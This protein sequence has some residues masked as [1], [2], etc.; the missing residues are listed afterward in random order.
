MA[1][2]AI[3]DFAATLDS[4]CAHTVAAAV[5]ADR[6]QGYAPRERPL[7][8]RSTEEERALHIAFLQTTLKAH[9]LWAGYGVGVGTR[10]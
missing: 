7:A 10:D 5:A 6:A 8:A 1:N 3:D 4:R 9:S 2:A